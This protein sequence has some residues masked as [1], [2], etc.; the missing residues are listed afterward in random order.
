[1]VSA[2]LDYVKSDMRR[3]SELLDLEKERFD[4]EV[5]RFYRESSKIYLLVRSKEPTEERL[6]TRDLEVELNQKHPSYPLPPT[7]ISHRWSVLSY[8]HIQSKISEANDHFEAIDSLKNDL[9]RF[10][11]SN[12]DI[13]KLDSNSKVTLDTLKYGDV[14]TSQYEM[15]SSNSI[16]SKASSTEVS[17][18]KLFIEIAQKF[19]NSESVIFYNGKERSPIDK[20]EFQPGRSY[21]YVIHK[22]EFLF[23]KNIPGAQH[24][25]KY[26]SSSMHMQLL[27]NHGLGEVRFAGTGGAIRF[28]LDGSIDISG[29]NW[30]DSTT[31][32]QRVEAADLAEA[33]LSELLPTTTTTTTTTIYKIHLKLDELEPKDK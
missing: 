7:R 15:N 19:E 28:N 33:F 6:S 4:Y 23:G 17:R 31:V 22:G 30:K 12:F 3:S 25:H 18:V 20:F 2:F 8:D 14:K 13:I 1:V 24:S 16:L 5:S 10:Y 32:E 11:V 26:D 21:G 29:H 27:E 9:Y